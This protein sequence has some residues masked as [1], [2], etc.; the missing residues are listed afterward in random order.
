MSHYMQRLVA[1]LD[2]TRRPPRIAP[3]TPPHFSPGDDLIDDPF[4]GSAEAADYEWPSAPALSA[5]PAFAPAPPPRADD[6]PRN[7]QVPRTP[8]RVISDGPPAPPAK[9]TDSERPPSVQPPVI[10]HHETVREVWPKSDEHR[11]QTPIDQP[12]TESSSSPLNAPPPVT[13][14]R[15]EIIH[16]TRHIGDEDDGQGRGPV[17]LDSERSANSRQSPL[18]PVMPP[19]TEKV[20]AHA[21]ELLPAPPPQAREPQIVQAPTPEPLAFPAPPPGGP[22]VV[23]G[24]LTV[25]VVP[26][27]PRPAPRP[28]A[29]R[30]RAKSRARSSGPGRGSTSAAMRSKLRYGMR[31]L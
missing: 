16:T 8:Q 15:R 28:P 12:D 6:V 4:D 27:P 11:E 14:V 31:Q 22:E 13:V 3:V 18:E 17:A 7:A 29:R 1:R 5:P 24:R 20:R 23:I 2:Q 19:I 26:E 10:H 21:P 9:S 25:Q 30:R